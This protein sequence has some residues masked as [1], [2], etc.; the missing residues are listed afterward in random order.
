VYEPV[1]Y[2]GNG[3]TQSIVTGI[4]LDA[5]EGLVWIKSR[6]AATN[7]QLFDTIRGATNL[8]TSN[9]NAIQSTVADS[10]TAFTATGFD[11]GAAAN[12]NTNA[13]TYV[14]WTF[15]ESAGFFDIVAYVG[16]GI[17][18]TVAHALTVPPE[19]MLIK[20]L[21]GGTNSWAVYTATTGATNSLILN[22]G[23]A[24][25]AGANS[26]NSTAPDSS[27]FTL[28][29]DGGV[30]N[31]ANNYIA[32]LF[33]TLA[34]VS[35]CGSYTGTGVQIDIDCGFAAPARFILIKRTDSTGSWYMWDSARGIG[36]GNDPYVVA[37]SG[38]AAEVTSTDYVD[39]FA[40][41]FSVTLGAALTVNV[42]AATYT[43]LAIA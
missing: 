16:T 39:T 3:A 38:A 19:I 28:N 40:T 33:A 24:A 17:A 32:Y 37:N 29:T 10:L 15:L 25:A 22:T 2:T 8:I 6:S 5:G 9:A 26:W 43:Y 21:D 27:V 42:L 4:D 34:G 30:N 14:A 12:V 13:A 11:I 35:K 18:R 7:S 36:S 23:A 1:I 20:R 31:N 41:G